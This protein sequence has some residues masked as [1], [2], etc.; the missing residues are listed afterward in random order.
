MIDHRY[1]GFV[2]K[3]VNY[4]DNDAIISVLTSSKKEVFKARGILKVTSKNASSCNYFMV[5]EFLTSSKTELSNQS[6]KSSSIVKLFKKPYEDLLVSGCYLFICSLL[7]Q[8]SEQINGYDL[9]IKCFEYFE[10]D[11]NPIN[12]LNYFLKHL[13]NALGYQS[14][15]KGCA[16]CNNKNNL[17][18]YDV[19]SGGFICNNCFDAT[20]YEKM[21]PNF[22]KEVYAFLT[23]EEYYELNGTHNIKLLGIYS[24]FLKDIV[25][26]NT[27][28][29]EF[30]LKCL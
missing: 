15:L 8:V 19:E 4:N 2:C 23:K 27:S 21:T 25:G 14:N 5:S 9:A 26:L 18:S 24:K 20:R 29:Y 10:E 3:K 22:L 12:V 17:V 1:K 16:N 30:I 7:D 11:K 28:S 13:C 6:L